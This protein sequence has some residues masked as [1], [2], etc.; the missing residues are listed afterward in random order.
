LTASQVL[1]IWCPSIFVSYHRGYK[2]KNGFY[3]QELVAPLLDEFEDDVGIDVWSGTLARPTAANVEA[4]KEAIA[5][6][7]VFV[8]FLSDAYINAP[9]C[10]REFL[11]AVRSG[12]FVVPVLLP[13]HANPDGGP[14]CGWKGPRDVRFGD[15]WRDADEVIASLLLPLLFCSCRP[16]GSAFLVVHSSDL[17]LLYILQRCRSNRDPDTG[18]PFNYSA[19]SNFTPVDMRDFKQIQKPSS[20]PLKELTRQVISRFHRGE[21]VEHQTKTQYKACECWQVPPALC[22]FSVNRFSRLI[23]TT[24]DGEAWLGEWT[25]PEL[26]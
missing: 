17:F 11:A 26:G 25:R 24:R 21:H 14:D 19:L 13:P 4:L 22:H 7:T 5:R 18:I 9:H 6:C 1:D 2:D 10:Q 23:H 8:V 15:W 20:F 12:K 3:T 16:H